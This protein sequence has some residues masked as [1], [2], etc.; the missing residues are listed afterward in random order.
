MGGLVVA[1][2]VG[3]FASEPGVEAVVRLGRLGRLVVGKPQL[4]EEP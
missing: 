1:Q 4:S 3:D 2:P